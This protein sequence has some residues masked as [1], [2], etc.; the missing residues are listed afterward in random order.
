MLLLVYLWSVSSSAALLTCVNGT[1]K[2]D[3]INCTDGV[4]YT[5][6]IIAGDGDDIVNIDNA[7]SIANHLYLGSSTS[8]VGADTL[9]LINGSVAFDVYGDNG[10]D[11]LNLTGGQLDGIYGFM[12]IMMY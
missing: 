8:S 10:I 7:T 6:H 4:A 5:G 11:T 12:A 1:K 3:T 9:N 2:N